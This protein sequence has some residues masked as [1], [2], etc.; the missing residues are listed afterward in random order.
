VHPSTDRLNAAAL[1]TPVAPFDTEAL[2]VGIPPIVCATALDADAARNDAPYPVTRAG[3][4]SQAKP[5]SFCRA[6]QVISGR[7]STVEQMTRLI[8]Q[9]GPNPA[10]WLPAFMQVGAS[11]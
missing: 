7:A 2:P 6:P 5:D 10:A 11:R 8:E 1:Q 9:V 3:S 4:S